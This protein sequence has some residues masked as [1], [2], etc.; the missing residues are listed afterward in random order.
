MNYTQI[1]PPESL[2]AYVRYFALLESDEVVNTTTKYKIIVDGC[3]GLIFQ[4]NT[5]GF[6]HKN[7]Q[8]LPQLFL[9]GLS[10]KHAEKTTTGAYRNIGVYFQPHAVKAIFGIDAHELTNQYADLDTVIKSNI[11]EQLLHEN[12]TEKRVGILSN[13]LLRQ[14]NHNSKK[15]NPAIAFAINT[16]KEAHATSL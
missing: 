3:P 5:N 15:E 6:L 1:L 9:H 10:T 14:I 13:F 12:S 7:K 4:E 11:T 16:I 2:R 8:T